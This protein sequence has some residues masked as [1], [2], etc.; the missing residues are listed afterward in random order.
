[1]SNLEKIKDIAESRIREGGFGAFSFREIAKEIGIKSASVHYHF[2][3]KT[4]LAVAVAKRYTE[5]FMASLNIDSEAGSSRE[6]LE[7][8]IKQFR[9]AAIY[10]KKMCL[11]GALAAECGELPE[12]V[13]KEARLFFQQN[14]EWLT[15]IFLREFSEPST[16]EKKAVSF[17]ATLEGAL[18]VSQVTGEKTYFEKAVSGIAEQL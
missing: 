8:Y 12:A 3:T 7:N 6:L 9:Q 15:A 1:M 14:I 18:L 10:D 11:C 5:R 13:H 17:L 16:A 2:P 4:D